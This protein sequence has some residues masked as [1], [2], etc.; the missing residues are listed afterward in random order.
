MYSRNYI[1]NFLKRL[2]MVLCLSLSVC[3]HNS[4]T[5]KEHFV[6][7]EIP[8]KNSGAL[9]VIRPIVTQMA[10]WNYSL[11]LYKYKGNFRADKNPQEIATIQLSNG[12][13]FQENLPEGFYK[14]TLNSDESV[15]KIFKLKNGEVCFLEFIIFSKS[16]FSGPEYFIKEIEKQ[17][18]LTYL[19]E[20]K[21]LIRE[22]SKVYLDAPK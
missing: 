9:Y 14:L 12:S 19:L 21:K 16:E 6:I 8:N 11:R 7:L 18:A 20:D 17:T 1:A 4:C 15:E 13:F 5:S 3:Q 22:P 10:I 2:S